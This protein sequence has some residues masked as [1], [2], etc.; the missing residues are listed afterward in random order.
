MS[1]IANPYDNAKAESFLRTLKHEEVHLKQYQTFEEAQTNIGQ[2]IEDVYNTKRL[3]SSLGYVPPMS[4]RWHMPSRYDVDFE[5][6]VVKRIDSS[7]LRTAFDRREL[8]ITSMCFV[9]W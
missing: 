5:A 4:L 3:H 6:G 7:W 2:F 9:L 1:A 8:T